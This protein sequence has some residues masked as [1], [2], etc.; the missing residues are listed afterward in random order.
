MPRFFPKKA[1]L[2]INLVWKTKFDVLK[3][4]EPGARPELIPTDTAKFPIIRQLKEWKQ[5]NPNACVTLWVDYKEN[6][7]SAQTLNE[8]LQ[9]EGVELKDINTLTYLQF[10]VD[11]D[12]EGSHSLTQEPTEDTVPFL[13]YFEADDWTVIDL[14]KIAVLM[15]DFEALNTPFSLFSDIDVKPFKV[16]PDALV[17]DVPFV[18]LKW[19]DKGGKTIPNNGFF[20]FENTPVSK[21][22]LNEWLKLAIDDAFVEGKNAFFSLDSVFSS[23]CKGEAIPVTDLAFI[24]HSRQHDEH[25]GEA[26]APGLSTK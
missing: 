7:T 19:T 4:I 6:P 26:S 21:K 22:L 23:H 2:H 17:Q 14:I 24:T 10:G 8:R 5:L 1:P 3:K 13:E 11:F 20:A 16:S 12:D 9:A 18:F 15:Y 25:S